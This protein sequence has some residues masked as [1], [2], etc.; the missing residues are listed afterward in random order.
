M[1]IKEA[2]DG[3][4]GLLYNLPPYMAA[5]EPLA[6]SEDTVWLGE[7]LSV[8]RRRKWSI[9]I[10]TLLAVLGALLYGRQ[11]TP[12]YESNARVNATVVLQTLNAPQAPNMETEQAFV[13]SDDVTKCAYAMMQNAGFRADPSTLPDLSSLCSSE[14]LA[15]IELAGPVRGI[16]QNV[17]VTTAPPSSVMTITYASP[18][19]HAAQ[20]ASQAFANAYIYERQVQASMQLDTL[21][22]PLLAKQEDLNDDISNLNEKMARKQDDIAK[23]VDAGDPTLALTLELNQ[24]QSEWDQ[25]RQLDD[26]ET[27]LRNLDPSHLSPPQL[28]LPAGLP[29]DPVSPDMVLI[30]AFGLLAGL[31][32]GIALAFLR[33]RL[34]D[35]LRGRLDLEANLGAPVLAVIPKVPGW[36]NKHDARLVTREQPKSTVAE[37]YRTLRTSISFLYAQRGLRVLMITSPAAGEGKTTTAANLALVLADAGKRV[38]LV[39]ADLRKPRIHRFFALPNDV[40]LSSVLAEE[41]Q[42]W[43]AILDPGVENLRVLLS[44]PVPSR[45]A[46]LLQSDQMSEILTGLREVADYVIIDTAPMLLVADALALAPLV[47]G[48]LFVADSEHTSRSAVAHAREQLEQVGV[49]VLG[50]VL[51]NFDPAKAKAYR[52]YGYYGSYRGYGRYGYAYYGPAVENG[53]LRKGEAPVM[54]LPQDRRNS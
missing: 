54:Q 34:D 23:A 4:R 45:P 28:L 27:S 12:I 1:N 8:L 49:V 36:R 46:E 33:E 13:T 32:L 42:P 26:I 25:R 30:G 51:N 43:E 40:G 16:Q 47:D 18:S 38:V 41:I 52:Q 35:S 24:L 21:R 39:S 7:Y 2:A 48:V 9:L 5:V 31:A 6:S 11:Q 19:T 22:A 44:G 20:V 53:E 15:G 10:I 3:M 50:S 17:S 14:A 37:A 29:Q